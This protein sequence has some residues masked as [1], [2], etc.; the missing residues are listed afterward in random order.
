VNGT[1]AALLEQ[2]HVV[3][4]LQADEDFCHWSQGREWTRV[5]GERCEQIAID[6]YGDAPL[7]EYARHVA[8]WAWACF[9]LGVQLRHQNVDHHGAYGNLEAYLSSMAVVSEIKAPV[10]HE[11]LGRAYGMRIYPFQLMESEEVRRAIDGFGPLVTETQSALMK[12][13]EQQTASTDNVSRDS[14]AAWREN[15]VE[16]PWADDA[17]EYLPL[18]EAAKLID[19]RLSLSTLSKWLT[20]KGEIRYMR[21]KGCGCKVHVADFRRYMQ[22][23]QGDTTFATALVSYFSAAGKGD[24]RFFWHCSQCGADYPEKADASVNCPKCKI[25]CMLI[26]KAPPQPRR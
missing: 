12:L 6:K 24:V 17:A 16:R 15:T 1:S 21:K 22:G 19:G 8:Y 9:W 13:T 11:A 5:L 2:A 25:A 10:I 20:P 3:G 14:Q 23:R 18:S 4:Q 26:R 7:D